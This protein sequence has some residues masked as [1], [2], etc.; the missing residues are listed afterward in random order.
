MLTASEGLPLLLVL[1]ILY[2]QNIV[3]KKSQRRR[4]PASSFLILCSDSGC[5]KGRRSLRSRSSARPF[6]DFPVPFVG[7]FYFPTADK[8]ARFPLRNPRQEYRGTK[9]KTIT[10]SYRSSLHC[11]EGRCICRASSAISSKAKPSFSTTQ[12]LSLV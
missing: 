6:F 5:R 11:Q 3:N 7:I 1:I 12:R 8:T 9:P 10:I 4:L 2:S